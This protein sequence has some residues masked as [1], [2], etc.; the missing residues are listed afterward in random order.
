MRLLSLEERIIMAKVKEQVKYNPKWSGIKRVDV[1]RIDIV[2]RS[3]IALTII[4]GIFSLFMPFIMIFSIFTDAKEFFEDG[5]QSV[6]SIAFG[7]IIVAFFVFTLNSTLPFLRMSKTVDKQKAILGGCV[8]IYETF[9]HMPIRKV[10][11]FK[12]SFIY[13][14]FMLFI[15]IVPSIILNIAILMNP[16]LRFAGG[17]VA[18]ITIAAVVFAFIMYGA[19]FGIFGKSRASIGKF[20]TVALAVFYILWM[21]CIFGFFDEFVMAEPLCAL[22]GVPCICFAVFGIIAVIAIE[23]LYVEKR[24]TNAAWSFKEERND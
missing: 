16:E 23:K 14:C 2:G 1:S 7:G 18:V 6:A 22:A 17:M 10:S 13:Y 5:F 21:G 3:S 12:Q 8:N 15:E 24:E 11:L 20:Y 19:V 4:F 9:A